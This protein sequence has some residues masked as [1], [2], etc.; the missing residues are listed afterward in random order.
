MKQSRYLRRLKLKLFLL[1]CSPKTLP[2]LLKAQNPRRNPARP[3]SRLLRHLRHSSQARRQLLRLHLQIQRHLHPRLL[4]RQRQRPRQHHHPRQHQRL[5]QRLHPQLHLLLVRRL[6]R[7]Q[8]LNP[9]PSQRRHRYRM[10]KL[11][12]IHPILTKASSESDITGILPT[13]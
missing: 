7:L 13:T 6:S 10:K 4:L 5:R 2:M 12:S 9:R 3:L 8:H 11:L 1:P